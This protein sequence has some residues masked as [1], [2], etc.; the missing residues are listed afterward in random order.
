MESPS[1]DPRTSAD[2]C[3]QGRGG[4]PGVL[5]RRV[6]QKR[7][8]PRSAAN[9]AKNQA[10]MD[11]LFISRLSLHGSRCIPGTFWCRN[12]PGRRI[13]RVATLTCHFF[14]FELLALDIRALAICMIE[15]CSQGLL[16]DLVGL[17]S[18]L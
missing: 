12:H 11:R 16:V 7:G 18:L 10:G 9:N 1:H 14:A 4:T 15:L 8:Q 2:I 17:A 6:L 5:S 13:A 3:N